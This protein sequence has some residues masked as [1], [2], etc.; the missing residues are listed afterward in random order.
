MNGLLRRHGTCLAVMA[1]LVVLNVIGWGELARCQ[2]DHPADLA[3]VMGC[4]F[5]TEGA[6][7]SGRYLVFTREGYI[8][9]ERPEGP[10]EQ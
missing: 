10:G 6:R 2:A 8:A 5:L 4:T 3:S 1:V 7:E 9:V